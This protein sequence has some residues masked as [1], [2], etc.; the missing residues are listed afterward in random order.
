MSS[1]K[2]NKLKWARVYRKVTSKLLSHFLPRIHYTHLLTITFH[3]WQQK[4]ESELS[5]SNP[6]L[7]L[8]KSF[9]WRRVKLENKSKLL[10]VDFPIVIIKRLSIK[11]K[12]CFPQIHYGSSFLNYLYPS[13]DKKII[14]AFFFFILRNK[15]WHQLSLTLSWNEETYK[16]IVKMNCFLSVYLYLIFLLYFIRSLTCFSLRNRER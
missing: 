7:R 4:G 10:F 15:T 3:F 13:Y 6:L 9:E 12:Q 8:L 11:E 5:H 16:N 2:K 14:A 1:P